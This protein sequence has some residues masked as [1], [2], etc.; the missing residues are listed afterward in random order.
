VYG[1]LLTAHA[2]AWTGSPT[3]FAFAWLRCSSGA[4]CVPHASGPTYRTTRDDLGFT[5][6]VVV[7]A[8]NGAGS[9]NARSDQSDTVQ[10]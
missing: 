6:I 3:D 9:R 1:S 8:T 4:N 7:T 5:F 10:T 2:G